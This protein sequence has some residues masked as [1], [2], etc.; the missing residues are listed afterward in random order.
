MMMMMMIMMMMMMMMGMRM[1][2]MMIM[3]ILSPF[4]LTGDPI[5]DAGILH[6]SPGVSV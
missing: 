2:M 5:A 1:R 6:G 4:A 3:T